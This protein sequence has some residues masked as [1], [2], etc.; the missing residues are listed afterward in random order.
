[1]AGPP[2]I[3]SLSWVSWGLCIWLGDQ[4]RDGV[5]PSRSILVWG[6]SGLPVVLNCFYSSIEYVI[7]TSS[8][9][10]HVLLWDLRRK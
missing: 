5:L 8:L 7:L 1:M 2:R 6:Y 3:Q 9:G 4:E 10:L